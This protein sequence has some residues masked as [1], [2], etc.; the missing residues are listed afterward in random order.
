[1]TH[2]IGLTGSIGM[3]KSTTAAMFQELGVPVWDADAAVH[4]L[5][6]TGGA[7]VGPLS[8]I[9]PE[10]HLD[11]KI[12]RSILKKIIQ[13]K[14]EALQTIEQIVHPL[15]ADDRAAF[16]EKIPADIVL[17]DIPLL[18]ETGANETMDTVICVTVPP[19]IQKERLLARGAMTEDQ[20]DMI[21]KNQM[22]NEKKCAIS[23]YVIE[24]LNFDDTRQQVKAIVEEIKGLVD[25][26]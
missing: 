15:V 22:P 17:F 2:L 23:D 18:F 14:P 26:A 12:D 16:V 6:D 10:A 8:Q 7:A 11:G 4:R 21:L 25:H 5:Y 20:L 13:N 9:F 24:T 1:M 3:G 19:D